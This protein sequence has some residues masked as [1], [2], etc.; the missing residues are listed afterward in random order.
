MILG[1]FVMVFYVLNSIK[2]HG[3]SSHDFLWRKMF[4]NGDF[5]AA[6]LREFTRIGFFVRLPTL[7]GMA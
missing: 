7:G 3:L 2:N 6:N 5:L 4:C 1:F